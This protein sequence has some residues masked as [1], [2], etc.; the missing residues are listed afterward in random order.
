L[1]AGV[2][3]ADLDRAALAGLRREHVA[4]AGQ[5]SGLVDALDVEENLVLARDARGHPHGAGW[6]EPWV[7]ALG[8]HA[9][10]HRR[11][12]ALS[13]GERQRALV[14]RVLACGVR[15]VVLDEPTSQQDEA[16]AERV[17]AV[18]RQAAAA[19]TAV[20]AATHDP[21]LVDAADTV[22]TLG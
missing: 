12:G 14:A 4:L 19:G 16:N 5:G 17:V 13:G 3:L 6:V 22:L 7:D 20:V 8:L 18:L 2:D 21:V 11:A 15:L 9:V 1:L 10:R